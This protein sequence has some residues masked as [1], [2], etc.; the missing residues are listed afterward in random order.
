[1]I[2]Q[3]ST[4]RY[5]LN[6]IMIAHGFKLNFQLKRTVGFALGCSCFTVLQLIAC[7]M[8]DKNA[9]TDLIGQY[10]YVGS[11]CACSNTFH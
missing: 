2:D 3:Y 7:K 6:L 5:N 10:T 11:I 8:L 9:K 1:M 4:T